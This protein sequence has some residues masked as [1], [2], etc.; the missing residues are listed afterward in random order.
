MVKNKTRQAMRLK[1]Y[2]YTQAGGYFLTICT[3][4]NQDI[5]GEIINDDMVLNDFGRLVEDEWKR[6]EVIRKEISLDEFVIMPNHIHGIIIIDYVADHVGAHGREPLPEMS[7]LQ[8]IHT[9]LHRNP[10]SLGSIIA[11]FKSTATKRINLLRS[12]PGKTVWQRGYHDRIIRDE[13]ELDR[14]REYI[15]YNPLNFGNDES[16]F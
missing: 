9:P 2:D 12:T 10:G 16:L 13:K 15:L 11:G 8:V 5:F 6:T 14:V 7:E 3:Y 4:Q 1:G